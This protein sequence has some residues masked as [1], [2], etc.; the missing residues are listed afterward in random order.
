MDA[1]VRKA[2][3]DDPQQQLLQLFEKRNELK[4]DFGKTLDEL[5]ALKAEHEQLR[6]LH[7]EQSSRLQGVEEVL[8]DE[9]RCQNA[10]IYYRFR[11]LHDHCR[12]LLEERKRALIEKFETLERDKQVKEFQAHAAEEQ[13]Q[14]EKKFELL[15]EMHGEAKAEVESLEKAIAASQQLWH[16]FKRK[17]LNAAL[18]DAREA[19]APVAEK[20][21]KTRLELQ[22]VKD[23]EPPEYKGLGP[24][25]KREINLQLIALAQY[26]V[27]QLMENDF[28]RRARMV[29]VKSPD[30]CNF[31]SN[32]ECL[33]LQKPIR[34]AIRRVQEDD[35]R[36]EKLQRRLSHLRENVRFEGNGD[37]LPPV[38]NFAKLQLNFV[39]AS[40]A[41]HMQ[42]GGSEIELNVIEESYWDLPELLL[43]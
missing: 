28:S 12:S 19:L 3:K 24:K 13:K 33:A 14:L 42:V 35:K 37:T 18:A 36:A 40:S 23:G 10:V 30:E 43:D 26:L 38:G 39:S 32:E 34:D 11:A 22:R 7:D 27:V 8:L 21:E 5:E 29:Q 25:S 16:F 41:D 31:G 4:R 15:D 9:T 2:G 6:Q 17:K 1:K 20:H